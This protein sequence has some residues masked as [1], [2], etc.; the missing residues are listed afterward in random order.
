MPNSVC[1]PDSSALLLL[2][3]LC[4]CVHMPW[5]LYPRS[6]RFSDLQCDVFQKFSTAEDSG[7]APGLSALLQQLSS[8]Y[9]LR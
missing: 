8:S 9:A 6:S 2:L 4:A 5:Q 1:D 3:Y 7:S